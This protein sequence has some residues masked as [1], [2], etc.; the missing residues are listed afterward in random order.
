MTAGGDGLPPIAVRVAVRLPRGAR[1]GL[2]CEVA[3]VSE[4][5]PE[6]R[7][8]VTLAWRRW[9]LGRHAL[10][11][12]VTLPRGVALPLAV[13]DA[14]VLRAETSVAGI[15]PRRSVEVRRDGVAV[16]VDAVDERLDD[17]AGIA[18]TTAP[19]AVRVEVDGATAECESLE[20]PTVVETRTGRVH[21][22][23][24]AVPA[25]DLGAPPADASSERRLALV[26]QQAVR[27]DRR[28][29]T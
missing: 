20:V 28:R 14:V 9:L 18:V 23:G 3:E 22:I 29:P 19:P 25:G 13:G 16:L 6:R 8:R 17:L 4:E 15:H 1:R 24:R 7:W 5:I 11:L 2:A 12:I 10:P 26:R 21:F 27:G